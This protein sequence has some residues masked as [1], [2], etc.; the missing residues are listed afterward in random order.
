MLTVSIRAAEASLCLDLQ[1]YDLF[2]H[3]SGGVCYL[4]EFKCLNSKCVSGDKV[5]DGENDC[6]DRSDEKNC[7]K[8]HLKS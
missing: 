8:N 4:S 5:C 7:S 6:G 3:F 1:K 2:F